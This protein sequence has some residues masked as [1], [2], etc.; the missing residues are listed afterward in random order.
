MKSS[1]I[2]RNYLY[3]ASPELS[4]CRRNLNLKGSSMNFP[5]LKCMAAVAALAAL[6]SPAS[7]D[8]VNVTYTGTVSSVSF[9]GQSTTATDALGL[10]GGGDLTGSNFTLGF[11]FDTSMGSLTTSNGGQSLTATASSNPFSA[12]ITING[13]TQSVVAP[14]NSARFETG[15]G[16]VLDN[17]TGTVPGVALGFNPDPSGVQATIGSTISSFAI[18]PGLLATPSTTSDV[19]CGCGGSGQF[20]VSSALGQEI[21]NLDPT[22]AVVSDGVASA[23]PEPSTW[24]MM[25]LGFCGVGFMA[26]R[27]KQNGPALRLA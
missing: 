25:I 26:Y 7:A 22:V 13:I 19:E 20:V 1:S 12:L 4:S 21:V 17:L 5:S 11:T 23:V 15:G 2:K 6:T 10:F 14:L 27:R 3:G 9:S 24:A 18:S 16:G 8:I